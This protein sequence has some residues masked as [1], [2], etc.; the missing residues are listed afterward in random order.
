MEA[1]IMS[2]GN[3][4][5][6]GE[7]LDTNS[8]ELSRNLTALGLRV[9]GRTTCPDDAGA[10]AKAINRALRPDSLI[11]L[12]GGLGPTIDDVTRDGIALAAGVGLVLDGEVLQSIRDRYAAFGRTMPES[13][14]RQAEFPEG[15]HLL[16]N[17]WGTAPAF[18]VETRGC[19]IVAL[20]GVPREARKIFHRILAPRLREWAPALEPSVKFL[21]KT[22]GIGESALEKKVRHLLAKLPPGATW[23]SLPHEEGTCQLSIIVPKEDVEAL[24]RCQELHGALVAELGNR[25]FSVADGAEFDWIVHD[26]LTR[27]GQ[28][29]SVAESCTGGLVTSRLVAMAGSSVYLERGAVCY[30]N[31]AKIDWLGV[32]Q[33]SLAED[34]AASEAVA[35]QMARGVRNAASAD[36][37]LA[38]TGIAGPTGGSEEKPVGMVY[39]ALDTP[40]GTRVLHRIFPGDRN[41]IRQRAATIALDMLRIEL[42]APPT[43]E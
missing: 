13:N 38:T 27:S 25:V 31:Q 42:S 18:A 40:R 16:G 22:V 1:Q 32:T 11:F 8:H 21:V 24:K 36:L 23:S 5:L 3:E 34:G 30:A 41:L 19:R 10:I 15:V 9:V 33:E 2:V 43:A 39:I 20:P 26:L 29:L 17:P 4:L 35:K 7:V 28:R 12:V 37:G 14:R 6:R